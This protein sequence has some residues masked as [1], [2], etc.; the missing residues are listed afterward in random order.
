M[1]PVGY[2]LLAYPP[3]YPYYHT[4][5][6]DISAAHRPWAAADTVAAYTAVVVAYKLVAAYTAVVA[7]GTS[8]RMFGSL[9]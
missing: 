6:S 8:E 1:A 4:I 7:S 9:G 5:P 3:Q 2:N